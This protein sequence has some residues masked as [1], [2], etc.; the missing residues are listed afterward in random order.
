MNKEDFVTYEQALYLKKLGFRELCLYRYE[1][2]ELLPNYYYSDDEV[3]VEDLYRSYNSYSINNL[4]Y[5]ANTIDAPTLVQVQKWLRKTKKYNI[6]PK[7]IGNNYWI[8]EISILDTT[9]ISHIKV[10]DSYEEAL[11]A[12]IT[13]CLK[14]L[15]KE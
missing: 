14:L 12:G 8:A 3:D 10:Y 7:Y 5:R 2:E 15:E 6:T 11:S 9:N 13:E 1:K 4:E